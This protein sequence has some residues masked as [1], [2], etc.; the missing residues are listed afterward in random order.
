[1]SQ[2]IKHAS[3]G[4]R[5]IAMIIDS[6]ILGVAQTFTL[7]GIGMI[8]AMIIGDFFPKVGNQFQFS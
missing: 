6:V 8:V 5:F 1:M 7:F 3:F 4:A 2:N